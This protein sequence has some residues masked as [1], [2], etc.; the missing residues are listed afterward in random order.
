[1]FLASIERDVGVT[2]QFIGG[3]AVVRRHSEADRGGHANALAV[4]DKW[5]REGLGDALCERDSVP[6]PAGA[7]RITNSS[8]PKRE[9]KSCGRRRFFRRCRDRLDQLVAGLM[10]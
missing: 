1:M 4:E 3:E 5:R 8:P 10:A 6:E 2:H 9:R 7:E